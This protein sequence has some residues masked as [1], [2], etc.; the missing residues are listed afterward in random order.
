MLATI[1][2]PES[3]HFSSLTKIPSATEPFTA[4]KLEYQWFPTILQACLSPCCRLCNTAQ[5]MMNPQSQA[6]SPGF[7]HQEVLKSLSNALFLLILRFKGIIEACMSYGSSCFTYFKTDIFKKMLQPKTSQRHFSV[8]PDEPKQQD[9]IIFICRWDH[10]WV[11]V[12][13]TKH[14]SLIL[15]THMVQGEDQFTQVVLWYTH[16]IWRARAHI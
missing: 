8:M 9:A 1:S 14:L 5:Q 15:W 7:T 3:C 2:A 13:A 12:L 10:Q 16:I 11:K 4:S 6:W